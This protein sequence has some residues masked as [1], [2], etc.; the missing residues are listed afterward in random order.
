MATSPPTDISNSIPATTATVT[1]LPTSES[2]D[3]LANS[4]SS[5][6]QPSIRTDAV[7][8]PSSQSGAKARTPS[9]ILQATAL[10]RG[11][12]LVEKW[13]IC[14]VSFCTSRLPPFLLSTLSSSRLPSSYIFFFIL[15][16]YFYFY[17]LLYLF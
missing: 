16:L 8:G 7:A 14:Y 1:P 15:Y 17:L 5:V 9:P 10:S 2:I 6:G 3:S 4:T 11:K 13:K 12:M